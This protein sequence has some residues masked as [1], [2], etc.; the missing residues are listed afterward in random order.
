MRDICKISTYLYII[1]E[2][3]DTK[4][5]LPTLEYGELARTGTRPKEQKSSSANFQ[6]TFV[7][8][9]KPQGLNSRDV[10]GLSGSWDLYSLVP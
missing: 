5:S 3:P 7:Y 6:H 9:R 4:F 1:N 2:N 8:S 10:V